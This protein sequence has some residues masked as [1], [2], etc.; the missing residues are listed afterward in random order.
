V[1]GD[2]GMVDFQLMAKKRPLL[3][4]KETLPFELQVSTATS[5]AQGVSGQLDV[6]PI[7]P[8]WVPGLLMALLVLLC[9]VAGGAYTLMNQQNQAAEATAEAIAN[10]QIAATQTFEAQLSVAELGTRTAEEAAAATATSLAATAVALGDD[11]G[12]G[13]S[14]Q[15]E[16]QLGTDPNNPDTDGDG[17]ND[18]AEVNQ[19]GTNPKNKDTDGDTLSDGDEVNIHGTSPTNPDTDGDGIPDGV[20]VAAGS[21][22]LLPPTATPPPT[23]EAAPVTPTFTPTPSATPPTA[24][25]IWD[26]VWASTCA[27]LECSAV[28]LRQAEDSD[29][30]TGSFEALDGSG[31]LVGIVEENRLTGTWSLNGSNGTFD[32]WIDPAGSVWQGN[33]DKTADWCGVRDTAVTDFPTPCGIARWYGEWATTYDTLTITQD[34]VNVEGVYANGDGTVSGTVDGIRISGNW[35]RSANSGTVAFFMQGNGDQFNGNWDAENAWCG[36]RNGAPAPTTC[37]NQGINVFII[38][39]EIIITL[40]PSGRFLPLPI[41]IPT[42]T[43]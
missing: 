10:A 21:N 29:T 20:E 38:P 6:T 12:D 2:T 33:W 31:T 34:G 26:G 9:I 41:V 36:Q 23:T 39:P 40:Q 18:G 8:P 16:L 14:N 32:F 7:L 19:Y 11:D 5:E 42:P 43:P 25:G 22:P 27:Y 1:A 30:V 3:G 35:F 28:T 13:L 15:Q 37:L 17:L 4:R 24:V